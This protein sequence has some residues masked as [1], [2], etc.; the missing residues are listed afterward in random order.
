MLAVLCPGQGAQAA[1]FLRPWLDVDG[2][3]GALTDLSPA[4]GFDLV[5]AGTDDAA[6][7]VDTA[8][9]QPLLVAAGVVT[10]RLLG[11]LPV[12]CVLVGHSIG[13][14]T[15]A[16]LAQV[17]DTDDAVALA[18][19]RGRAMAAAAAATPSGMTAVL[20]GDPDD[21]AAAVE[22]AGRWIANHNGPGQLVV[23]GLAEALGRLAENPPSGARLRA[24]PVAGAF[25]T[26]LMQPAQAVVAAAAARLSWQH[27]RHRVLSN[28]DGQV[29][30][31][32]PDLRERIVGQVTRP[33][34][35][36]RCL[37]SLRDLGVTATI[38]VAPGG[39]LTGLVRRELRDVSA[40]ALRTPGDLDAARRL[41]ATQAVRGEE[42]SEPWRVLVAP[43]TGTLHRRD[44]GTPG[45]GAV[46]VVSGRGGDV[47]VQPTAGDRVVE[48]LAG[49]GDPVREGQPLVRLLPAAP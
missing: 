34:R 42:W 47:P 26:P 11:D 16:T 3:A 17:V 24:L 23:G 4:A 37:Q 8:I 13:E 6:D 22:D 45:P 21:V 29:V 2:V 48:W 18:A 32:G 27:A 46:A 49:D 41:V 43:A 36:D 15:A 44:G 5:T 35:F 1:G 10:A 7:V 33:V 39:V 25:H 14:L 31:D 9:A 20:G 40:V 38:E 28:A 30:T 19:E 12:D